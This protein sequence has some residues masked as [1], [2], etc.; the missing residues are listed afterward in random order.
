VDDAYYVRFLS[1]LMEYA[2]S[3]NA[4]AYNAYACVVYLY[5]KF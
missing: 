2:N 4:T 1:Y 3:P 5:L